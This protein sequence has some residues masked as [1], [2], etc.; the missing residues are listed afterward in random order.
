M[1]CLVEAPYPEHA[2]EGLD[3]ERRAMKAE[4]RAQTLGQVLG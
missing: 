3:L 4:M 1:T 2:E